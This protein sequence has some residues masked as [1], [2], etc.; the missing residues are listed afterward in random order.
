VNP[1]TAAFCAGCGRPTGEA[2]DERDRARTTHERG[3]YLDRATSRSAIDG[4]RRQVTVM[5]ADLRGSLGVIEGSDPEQVQALLDAVVSRMVDSVERY[6]GTVNQVMGDGIMA[7]FGAPV[8]HEDHVARAANAALQMQLAVRDLRDPAWEALSI[9]PQI[10]IGM[11]S[12][13]VLVRTTRTELGLEYRALGTTT[14]MA[15]RMEQLAEPGSVLLTGDTVRLGRGMLRT[16][17]LGEQRIKGASGP[18][19]I[20]ELLGMTGRTRFQGNLALGVS[21]LVGREESLG[22]LRDALER[23][24]CD[25]LRAVVVSGEP[26]VGKSRL[27]YEALQEP[28]GARYRVLEAAAMSYGRSRPH[29]VL[30]TLLKELLQIDAEDSAELVGERVCSAAE[31]LARAEGSELHVPA[32]RAL[33]DLPIDDGAW[34]RLDPSQRKR[35]VEQTMRA[36]LDAE[37]GDGPTVLLFEDMHWADADTLAFVSALLAEGSSTAT[38]VLLTHR[39]ELRVDWAD[40]PH[41]EACRLHGLPA[42]S[43]SRLLLS[44]LGDEDASAAA[45]AL[46]RQTQGNP[47]FIEES[48]RAL[49]ERG[50]AGSADSK[51]FELPASVESLLAAR[52]DRLPAGPVELLQAAAVCGDETPAGVLRRVA[53]LDQDEFERR[54]SILTDQDLL[55]ETRAH[56]APVYSFKHALI[57]DV[58]YHRL[59]TPRLRELHERAADAIEAL[60]PERLGEYVERLAEHTHRAELWERALGYYELASTRALRA[61]A[62]AQAWEHLSKALD[63]VERLPPGRARTERAVDLRL[64]AMAPLVPLGQHTRTLELLEEAEVMAVE[65][66]DPTRLTTLHAQQGMTLWLL[67]ENRR[68]QEVARRAHAEALE[69]GDPR[70]E[71]ATRYYQGVIHHAL[72]ELGPAME[73]LRQLD[74]ELSGDL[75]RQRMGWAG[76]P[77]CF[78]GTFCGAAL[79]LLGGFDEATEILTRAAALGEELDHPYSRTMVLEELGF[80]QLMMGEPQAARRTLELAMDI[81]REHDVLVMHA[82]IAARLGRALVETGASREGRAVIEDALQRQTYR[83]AA[84]YGI[85]YLLVAH[86]FAQLQAGEVESALA[87]A[88]RAVEEAASHD[89]QA[90][91]VCAMQQRAD[92]LGAGGPAMSDCALEAYD[93]TLAAARALGMRPFEAFARQGRSGVLVRAGQHARAEQDRRAALEIWRQLGAPARVAALQQ[94]SILPEERPRDT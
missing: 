26:G 7:L 62:S 58:V 76:Y 72:G 78:V 27:C 90:Y 66:G 81:C 2:A 12:G 9:T 20:H 89:E 5:F 63:V 3:S 24:P 32:M 84:H 74:R 49:R 64:R 87:T 50:E 48:A 33:L 54:A 25:G 44:L 55:F 60:F 71:L 37:L 45:D 46:V 10:R 6:G 29:G 18:V 13:E 43:A 16:R 14:H 31:R 1:P 93:E 61:S 91:R 11:D 59:L 42:D 79:S 17:N 56:R 75:A 8:A 82:P 68:A 47:F 94:V 40:L 83:A 21:P 28:A 88:E 65:L 19:E 52:V 67:A 73:I 30:S 38:V 70:T 77:A 39:P 53:S 92:V 23:A 36:L 86:A 57:G 69:L 15:A 85:D 35:G 80:L 34:R 22:V 4:E 41:V 51:R